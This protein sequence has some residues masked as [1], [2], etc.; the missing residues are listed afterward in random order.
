[1]NVQIIKDSKNDY[2]RITT[3]YIEFPRYIES[4]ILRHRV[5]SFS[6]ESSRAKNLFKHI[7]DVEENTTY[8]LWTKDGKGMK[9]W[10]I[11]E[12]KI[13][14]LNLVWNNI[15]KQAIRTTKTLAELGVHKQHASRVLHP[16][17]IQKM[18]ITGTDFQGFFDL[19]LP[20]YK[21]SNVEKTII[22][23][24][25][26]EAEKVK[27]E[28]EIEY[29][30]SIIK[31]PVAQ[32]EIEELAEKMWDL[33]NNNLPIILNPGEWHIPFEEDYK[34]LSLED[35]LKCSVARCA[36]ISYGGIGT[37]E[38]NKILCDK[39]IT[40]QHWSCF[41]HQAKSMYEQDTIEWQ[42]I[43]KGRCKKGR[44]KNFTGFISNRTFYE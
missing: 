15:K 29:P 7:K 30:T 10:S 8:P 1:M 43:E 19:R 24:S 11:E 18:I 9:G 4:Q 28:M 13:Q 17:E 25:N 33:Y 34:E 21:V 35:K 32:P 36:R 2:G 44:C 38:T 23:R 31:F 27:L 16:F 20:E 39:L 42:V 41:E 6:A 22:C 37:A 5:F 26:K 3:F 40:E 14:K 12:F